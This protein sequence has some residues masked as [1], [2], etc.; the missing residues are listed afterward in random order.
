[1]H[2]VHLGLPAASGASCSS[3]P[4]S[5]G[6]QNQPCKQG[7]N[8]AKR[9]VDS[10]TG[11]AQAGPGRI[12]P[13]QPLLGLVRQRRSRNSWVGRRHQQ[14]LPAIAPH[15]RAKGFQPQ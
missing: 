2:G 1:M 3:A 12:T 7:R 6:W 9:P 10:S 15:P 13:I 4:F 11:T 14:G 8:P 5:I